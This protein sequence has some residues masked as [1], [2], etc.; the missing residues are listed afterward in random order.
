QKY[1][2]LS[3]N[4]SDVIWT[5]NFD[6]KL[7]YVSPSIEKLRGF[8]PEESIKQ[9]LDE[10]LMPESKKIFEAEIAKVLQSL[11]SGDKESIHRILEI[12]QP[13]KDGTTVLTEVS[14]KVIFDSNG[15]PIGIQG[16]S[17][18]I[19][20][21]KKAELRQNIAYKI[22]VATNKSTNLG[23]LLK[24]IRQEIGEIM[25]TKNF[26]IAFYDAHSDFLTFPY[27]VDETESE[28]FSAPG[29]KFGNG[30]TEYVIKR[31]SGLLVHDDEIMQ[32]IE[33]GEIELIGEL[34][35]IWLGVP[36][37]SKD[38]IIGVVAVQSD[39]SHTAYTHNDLKFLN[40]ISSQIASAIERK[41]AEE[42]LTKKNKE[43]ERFNKLAVG[44][45]L[46]MV[47]LKKEKNAL[48]EKLGEEPRYKIV[49]EPYE[50]GGI[51]K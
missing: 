36:L 24:Y 18:D 31:D 2:L 44:R 50:G 14:A 8:T 20:E 48:L 12:K 23:A 10:I 3:E 6:G 26:Y 45:E 11:S 19:T 27:F 32:L 33:N 7:T 25:D 49:D 47:E 39:T 40:F 15:E 43:L 1:R 21:R 35:L 37:R 30:L 4:S 29:R 41:Q 9:S 13:C 17:R 51:N 42:S 5:M 34:P 28:D 22:A 16:V 46:K 38:S